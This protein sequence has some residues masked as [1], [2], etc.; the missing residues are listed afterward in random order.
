MNS[1]SKETVKTFIACKNGWNQRFGFIMNVDEIEFLVIPQT[2]PR[3]CVSFYAPRSGDHIVDF[4]L[5]EETLLQCNTKEK[6]RKMLLSYSDKIQKFISMCGK[7]H[8]LKRDLEKYQENILEFGKRPETV[9][10][11]IYE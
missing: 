8:L 11:S 1:I 9:T 2:N 3:L 4:P 5:S 10:Q 7:E 6:T